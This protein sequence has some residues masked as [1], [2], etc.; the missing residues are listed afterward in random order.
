VAVPYWSDERA[1][2]YGGDALAVLAS[3]P[4]ASVD[5]VI[6]DPP[7]S[8]GGMLRGDRT[9]DVHTKYIRTDSES[10]NALEAFSGDTRDAHGYWFW[11]SIWLSELTRVVQPGGVCAVFTDWRQLA[12]T[13]GGIQS[14]GWVYRGVVPWYKPNARPT[15]S[16]WANACEYVVWGTNGPR[17]LDHLG[18]YALPGFFQAT[19]PTSAQREHIT[20]KPLSVMRE[21]VRI[22]PKGGRVLDPFMGTGTT[23][24]A[25]VIEG[26]NFIGAELTEHYQRVARERIVAAQV[27]YRDDGKQ[28]ALVMA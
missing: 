20:Q 9:Q 16:R 25:A 14:G 24:I 15:Q 23:G 19:A 22:A 28:M 21:L 5:A 2:L 1:T 3:L 18:T 17:A 12:V 10:G 4:D 6:T 11:C 13:I 7:Y 8:S 26:R 27:G